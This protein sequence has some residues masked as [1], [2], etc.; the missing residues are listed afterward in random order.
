MKISNKFREF[1]LKC[2]LAKSFEAIETKDFGARNLYYI[3][4]LATMRNASK[5]LVLDVLF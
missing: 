1:C 3:L 2:L 4:A 5:I